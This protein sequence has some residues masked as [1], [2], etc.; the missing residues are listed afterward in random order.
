MDEA[1][2]VLSLVGMLVGWIAIPLGACFLVSILRG[3]PQRERE[4]VTDDIND[5]I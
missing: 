3:K 4:E 5:V 1:I 2:L